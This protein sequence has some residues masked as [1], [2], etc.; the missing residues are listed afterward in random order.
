MS[1]R[2]KILIDILSESVIEVATGYVYETH[3]TYVD[4]KF[5]KTIHKNEGW[6]FHWKNEYKKINRKVFKLTLLKN[7]VVL[8]GLICLEIKED[9]VQVH[10]IESTPSNVGKSKKYLGIGANLFAFACKLSDENGFDGNISFVSKTN[11]IKHYSLN[12]GAI[13]LGNGKMIVREDNAKKLIQKYYSN[14]KQ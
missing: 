11:L 12:L 5:I 13:H 2:L 10:L 9:H 1:I 7:Q 14:G 3:M 6:N 4:S 8:L